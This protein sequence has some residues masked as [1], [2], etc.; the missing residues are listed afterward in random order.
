VPAVITVR[1]G[2]NFTVAGFGVN[3][4]SISIGAMWA[5]L[6]LQSRLVALA[7][8]RPVADVIANSGQ[9]HHDDDRIQ[10]VEGKR[11]RN[12]RDRAYIGASPDLPAGI[13]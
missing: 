13:L 2:R 9:D 10:A 5:A 7:A 1:P 12:S 6:S 11:R 4:V 8:G 3:S